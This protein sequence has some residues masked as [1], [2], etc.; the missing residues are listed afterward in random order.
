M[1]NKE[2][3]K[4]EYQTISYQ[5]GKALIDAK[6]IEGALILP[7]KLYNLRQDAKSKRAKK[8]PK[9]DYGQFLKTSSPDKML[10]KIHE[11]RGL[12]GITEFLEWYNISAIKKSNMVY[13]NALTVKDK[14]PNL[15]R[16]LMK[17][18]VELSANKRN[19]KAYAWSNYHLRDSAQLETIIKKLLQEGEKTDDQEY[20]E[21]AGQF[22]K[23]ITTILSE[24]SIENLEGYD[25][26][27]E[28]TLLDYKS[29][30]FSDLVLEF[31]FKYGEEKLVQFVKAKSYYMS[32]DDKAFL[33]IKM[34]KALSAHDRKLEIYFC[35]EALKID[36]S[37][38]TLRACLWAFQ[39]SQDFART[40]IILQKLV[41]ILEQ[42]SN[43]QQQTLLEKIYKSP[44]YSL[45]IEKYIPS[46]SE[47][48][49]ESIPNRIAYILHN[50]F[51]YSSGGYATR[52]FGIA[53]GLKKHGFEVININRP[54]FPIDIKDDL[55][56]ED[57]PETEV[58]EGHRYVR[59]LS[60]SRR[61]KTPYDY[62][63]EA[64][65]ILEKRF[66]EYRP[67]YVIAA[68]NHITAIPSLIAAKRL[69]IPFYYEVR[70][71]WEITR[72]SREPEFEK[73]PAYTVQV[74]L[75]TLAAKHATH[76]FTLTNPMIN[77][78]VRRGVEEE[79]ISLVPNSCSPESL[80]PKARDMELV[81]RL[82][83]PADVPVIGYI[84]TFVQYEGLDDLAEACA[85]LKL[86]GVPFRLLLVGNE[87]AS[88]QDVGPITAKISELATTYGF[89]DWL[90]MPG[91]IPFDE[92][93]S[94]Y[95]L[96]DIAP[97][98]RKPQPVCE[99]V[100]PMKPLEALAMKKAV[101][102]SSVQALKEMIVEQKTGLIFE[103]GNI[104]DLA[105][106]L[107]FLIDN[108][109]LRRTLG[110]NGRVWV[111]SERN[112]IKTT[113]VIRDQLKLVPHSQY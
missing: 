101:L 80:I 23:K 60:T 75:E 70:G 44:A 46:E 93:E 24:E 8:K 92:V 45:L 69:G 87:N 106:K 97:F 79:S 86:K 91:R 38:K 32:K 28:T 68:S 48:T 85:I 105:D 49:I 11:K 102:V 110:E 56:A 71:L 94:Y 59:S 67:Q 73:K 50:S 2:T 7:W 33:L 41:P 77:E 14:N 66:I 25:P 52:A 84:G 74:L 95:S 53:E 63:L 3:T 43:P 31:Y 6:T 19:L 47:D 20:I 22:Q 76:V 26:V 89:N 107:Q 4:G 109:G 90:I 103:K 10:I 111:E 99:L 81:E 104:N 64:S 37:E 5:L 55:N 82:N 108:E 96:I 42:S 65:D 18:S 34:S 1:K 61:G 113:E 13:N 51:P 72:V 62:M 16:T 57:V 29:T 100:S 36:Q 27:Y 58:I 15:Y 40:A 112:W 9:L 54:G 83:I 78:L 21:L 88:G 12:L 17:L 30:N 39:K 98:P 35:E